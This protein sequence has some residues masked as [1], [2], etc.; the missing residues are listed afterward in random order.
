MQV[1]VHRLAARYTD[2]N[3]CSGI[4]VNLANRYAAEMSDTRAEAR[5]KALRAL[6]GT[7]V[8]G[9]FATQSEM[10]KA[11]G[12]VEAHFSQMKTGNRTIGNTSVDRIE[13]RLGLP[14]GYMDSPADDTQGAA[15]PKPTTSHEGNEALLLAAYRAASADAR[16]LLLA[17]AKAAMTQHPRALAEEQRHGYQ[18]TRNISDSSTTNASQNP[19][20]IRYKK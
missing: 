18:I 7:H 5:R 8:P 13:E 9:R 19:K 6:I 15:A 1:H 14:R 2:V 4:D 12:F 10:A 11:L 17:A 16:G 20:K 3:S